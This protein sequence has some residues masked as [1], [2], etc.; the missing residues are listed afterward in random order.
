M[1]DVRCDDD[2]MR[3]EGTSM[4]RRVLLAIAAVTVLAVAMFAIPLAIAVHLLYQDEAVTA[5]QSD[6]TWIATAISQQ[7]SEKPHLPL[8]IAADLTVGLYSASGM[9]LVGRGPRI[10]A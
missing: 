4:R 10:P 1:P 8:G 9:R 3:A 2:G 5:L 6:A 7:G